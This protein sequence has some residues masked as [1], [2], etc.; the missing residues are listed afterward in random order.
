MPCTEKRARLWR[1]PVRVQRLVPFVIRLTCRDAS[2]CE[3]RPVEIKLDPWS[4]TTGMAVVRK[5]T[6]VD[7][8][9]GAIAKGGR[10]GYQTL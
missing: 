7:H 4:K 9:T 8:E 1:D 3:I 5:V 10:T 6:V 2:D